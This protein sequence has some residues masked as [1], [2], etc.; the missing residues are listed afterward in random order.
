MLLKMRTS[1]R[2]PGDL[3]WSASEVS[4]LRSGFLISL[5]LVAWWMAFNFDLTSGLICSQLFS[6]RGLGWGQRG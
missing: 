5:G 6:F 3:L 1:T 4:S 2:G